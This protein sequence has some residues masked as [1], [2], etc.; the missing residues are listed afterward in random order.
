MKEAFIAG[1]VKAGMDS[2]LD[3]NSI[4]SIFKLAME[5]SEA[6]ELFKDMPSL[7]IDVSASELEKLSNQKRESK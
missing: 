5:K 3:D 1:F 4:A 6:A 7:G 2:G